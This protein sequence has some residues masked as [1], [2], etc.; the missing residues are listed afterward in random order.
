MISLIDRGVI[1]N[2]VGSY[3][4]SLDVQMWRGKQDGL[5]VPGPKAPPCSTH[6]IEDPSTHVQILCPLQKTTVDP[7]EFN[8]SS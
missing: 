5:R 7:E 8:P 3:D 2:F 4:G 1:V 6:G